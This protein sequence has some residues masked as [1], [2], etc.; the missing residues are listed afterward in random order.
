MVQAGLLHLD[1]SEIPIDQ[2]QTFISKYYS[3]SWAGHEFLAVARNDN[4]WKKAMAKAGEVS[5]P[6]L[7]QLLT[8]YLKAE[9]KLP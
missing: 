3:I 2:N 8:Q 4:R 9:L 5:L 1:K 7:I 6:I